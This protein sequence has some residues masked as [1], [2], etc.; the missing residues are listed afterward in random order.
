MAE[1]AKKA[2]PKED[3]KAQTADFHVAEFVRQTWR[4]H[5]AVGVTKEHLLQPEHWA[6][7]SRQMQPGAKIEVL[8]QD[9][10]YYGEFL[11]LSAERT[12]A[13]VH[14]IYWVELTTRDVALSQEAYKFEYKGAKLKHCVIRN[15]DGEIIH[16]GSQTRDEA[17]A[18]FKE[19]ETQLTA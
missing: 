13:K 3:P 19:R 1:T 12:Y 9:G 2:P 7:V 14:A 17:L 15:S 10:T 5:P 16:S 4:Y 18:W 6:V 8:A 11:V